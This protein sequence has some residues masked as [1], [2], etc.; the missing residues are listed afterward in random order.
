MF[1]IPHDMEEEIMEERSYDLNKDSYWQ[2][3]IF[4]SPYFGSTKQSEHKDPEEL[5]FSFG[6]HI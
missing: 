3:L 4:P 5:V 1:I 2:V 6:R